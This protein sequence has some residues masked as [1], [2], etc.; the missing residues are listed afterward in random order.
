M[1]R[2]LRRFAFCLALVAAFGSALPGGMTLAARR[3]Y[4]PYTPYRGTQSASGQISMVLGSSQF[5]LSLADGNALAVNLTASTRVTDE[6]ASG[7]GTGTPSGATTPTTTATAA[8]SSGEYAV[9]HYRFTPAAGAVALSVTLSTAPVA[10]GKPHRLNGLV[11]GVG[12]GSFVL[13]GPGGANWTITLLPT[14]R[15][16]TQEAA[17]SGTLAIA[18]GDFATAIVRSGSGINDAVSV[19]Y[20]S[21]PYGSRAEGMSGT[22]SGV[23]GQ[24]LT[25]ALPNGASRTVDVLP[26]AT[27]TLNGQTSTLA[28]LASGDSVRVLG[29]MFQSTFYAYEVQATSAANG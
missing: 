18:V 25:L 6:L 8:F 29:S 16:Y 20:G 5:V 1:T 9:V 19:T 22:V 10:T 28:S 4:R 24:Q 14:T 3:P 26:T 11:T 13:E 12:S 17:T 21:R 27:V 15:V 7:S 2:R 23:S